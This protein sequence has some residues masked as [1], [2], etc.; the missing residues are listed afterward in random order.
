MHNCIEDC[1]DRVKEL[2]VSSSKRMNAVYKAH[3]QSDIF[4]QEVAFKDALEGV[5]D[6]IEAH[7]DCC[8]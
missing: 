1:R 5:L 3:G 8:S 4:W 6:L 7:I 2:I